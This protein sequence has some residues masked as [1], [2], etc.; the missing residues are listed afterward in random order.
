MLFFFFLL[1]IYLFY[2]ILF[3]SILFY[4]FYSILF[5]SILF[6]AYTIL[7]TLYYLFSLPFVSWSTTTL[8]TTN[9][10]YHYYDY[11]YDYFSTTHSFL[12]SFLPSFRAVVP[13][14]VL[15]TPPLR[16]TS[17]QSHPPPFLTNTNLLANLLACFT[18]SLACLPTY[19]LAQHLLLIHS[20]SHS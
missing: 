5:Y 10:N 8:P 1:L 12:P 13:S 18:Y 16:L 3:Y 17:S 11:D 20:L 4:L 19:L 7:Y 14:F 9:H 15:L 2:S 6:Y